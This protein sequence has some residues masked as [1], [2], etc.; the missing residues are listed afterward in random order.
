MGGGGDVVVNVNYAGQPLAT[1]R[2]LA[3]VVGRAVSM[4]VRQQGNPIFGRLN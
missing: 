3:D 1:D 4:A 2:Q